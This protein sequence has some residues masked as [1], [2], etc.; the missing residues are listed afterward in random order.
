MSTIDTET[1]GTTTTPTTPTPTGTTPTGTTP[2]NT[3][4]STATATTSGVDACSGLG[5]KEGYLKLIGCVDYRKGSHV[6]RTDTRSF[7]SK[8][9]SNMGSDVTFSGGAILTR[10][11]GKSSFLNYLGNG[12][13]LKNNFELELGVMGSDLKR[14]DNSEYYLIESGTGGNITSLRVSTVN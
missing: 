4:T 8:S 2:T 14:G 1:T 5:S 13:E 6:L 11:S 7:L 9:A 3:T 12:V 10:A